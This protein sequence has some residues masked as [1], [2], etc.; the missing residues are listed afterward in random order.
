MID[1]HPNVADTPVTR[2]ILGR[3]GGRVWSHMHVTSQVE[4]DGAVARGMIPTPAHGDYECWWP[5]IASPTGDARLVAHGG[6]VLAMEHSVVRAYECEVFAYGSSI[7]VVGSAKAV[8]HVLGDGVVVLRHG[9]PGW[10]ASRW[11]D[12]VVA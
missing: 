10:S 3:R 9:A 6:L 11:P 5:A 2:A 4:F 1:T 8:V 12:A 7:V